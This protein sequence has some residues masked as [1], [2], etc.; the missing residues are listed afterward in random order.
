VLIVSPEQLGRHDGHLT[1]FAECLDNPKFARQI[2][3]VVLDEGHNTYTAGTST[4]GRPSFRPAYGK[5]R[6]FLIKL[7]KQ[8][9]LQILSATVPLHIRRHI[10]DNLCI[11]ETK[12]L[13][14]RLTVNRPNTIYWTHQIK[15][16]LDDFSNLDF[17]VPA[18]VSE[19]DINDMKP[20]LIF[21]DNVTGSASLAHHLNA[22][23]PSSLQEPR[24][25]R[26]YHSSMSQ[27]YL[28]QTF[29]DFRQGKLKILVCTEGASTV[30]RSIPNGLRSP[31]KHLH[32][33]FMSPFF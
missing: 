16:S 8:T 3:R 5:I 12:L 1:H 14:I 32:R 2:T 6:Q 13:D 7:P 9:A 4:D 27:E 19:A 26:H 28:E 23:F 30:S 17:L 21:Y 24:M 11:N 29:E 25:A 15:G 33:E 22:R 31:F 10:I 18:G 20:I